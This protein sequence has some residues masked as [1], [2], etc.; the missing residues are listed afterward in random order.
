VSAYCYEIVNA[1]QGVVSRWDVE[2]P[3]DEHA[4]AGLEGLKLLD[5]ESVRVFRS[6]ESGPFATYSADFGTEVFA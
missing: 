6:D 3:S 2:H 5:G 4:V 1:G